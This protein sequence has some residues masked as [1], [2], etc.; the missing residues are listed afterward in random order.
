MFSFS[1]A[2]GFIA[3]FIG[4]GPIKVLLVYMAKA[5]GM[6]QA[7]RRAMAR[8][9]VIVAG[10]VGVGMF[11]LGALLQQVLHF[12]I[13]ALNIIG[14]LILLLLALNMVLGAGKP[15]AA[16][17]ESEAVDPMSLAVS[18]LAIPLT[19]N[20]VG[21]V[22]LVVASLEV[23]DLPSSIAVVVLIAIVMVIDFGVLLFS[24]KVAPYLSEATIQLLEVV[25][26]IFLGALAIQLMLN[27][28]AEVGAITLTGHG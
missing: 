8:R 18:P 22:T 4:M 27:G 24:D 25:L 12:S 20:P 2:E 9:I 23:T 28:L 7:T 6:D 21:I 26:G 3:L 10:S 11:A 1:L 14:G 15:K 17:A 16:A 5:A 19:L 13:G